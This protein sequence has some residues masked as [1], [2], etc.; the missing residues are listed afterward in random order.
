MSINCDM[1][2]LSGTQCNLD[3]LPS[4]AGFKIISNPNFPETSYHGGLAGYIKENLFKHINNIRCSKCSL[5]FGLSN[6]PNFCYMLFKY[7]LWTPRI[8][9]K[10]ILEY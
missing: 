9:T 7:T 6:L 2:M 3:L 8:T 10:Q 1:V 5:L 4:V